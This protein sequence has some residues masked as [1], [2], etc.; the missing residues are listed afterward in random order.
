MS[1]SQT[2]IKPDGSVGLGVAI[3]GMF[4]LAALGGLVGAG[5]DGI[6]MLL[7]LG[8]AIFCAIGG[9]IGGVSRGRKTIIIKQPGPVIIQQST[10][11]PT[12]FCPYCGRKIIQNA[13]HCQSCG[14]ILK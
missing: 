2:V 11:T 3:G 12:T 8:G 4:G 6:L 14:K 7:S 5:I 9:L 10:T 13:I 1:D